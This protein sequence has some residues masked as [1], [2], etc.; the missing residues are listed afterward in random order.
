MEGSRTYWLDLFTTK[1]QQ[2]FLDT[3]DEGDCRVHHGPGRTRVGENYSH[4]TERGETTVTLRSVVVFAMLI[5][6]LFAFMMT[7]LVSFANAKE[8]HGTY[9][10]EWTPNVHKNNPPCGNPIPCTKDIIGTPSADTIFGHMGWDYVWARGG[11]DNVYGGKSMDQL[12]GRDGSD[13]LIG[14]YG[15][16]HLFGNDG[17]DYLNTVDG[18]DEPG[19]VEH[20]LGDSVGGPEGFDKCVLDEDSLDG[21]ILVD[22]ET[23]V[24]KPVPGMDSRTPVFAGIAARV[25]GRVS[26]YLTPGT[27]SF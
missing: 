16:D 4:C 19:H 23:V 11:N 8:I 2:E 27:Y 18:K 25:E 1:T 3:E 22:C 7:V 14:Q 13:T 17:N 26:R 10:H 12:Y 9:R 5:G 20:I 15:H 24:I 6:A 21:I